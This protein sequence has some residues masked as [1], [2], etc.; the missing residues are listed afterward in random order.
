MG[1]TVKVIED[2][3]YASYND[4][5]FKEIFEVIGARCTPRI[6][7][8]LIIDGKRYFVVNVEHIIKS[9]RYALHSTKDIQIWALEL[10]EEE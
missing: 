4:Y 2:K 9:E 5:E 3:A 10:N 7:E 6:D 1:Y 8:T